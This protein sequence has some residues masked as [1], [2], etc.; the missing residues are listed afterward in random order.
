MKKL[1]LSIL[2]IALG[3]AVFADV[4][5]D[6]LDYYL[7]KRPEFDHLKEQKINRI[8][9]EIR[10][11]GNDPVVL[12]PL[13]VDLY[14]EYS[15]Y[16][17]DSATVCVKKLTDISNTL[18]DKEKIVSSTIKRAFG[19]L[20]SGLFKECFDI[21]SGLDVQNCSDE[22]KI[23]YYIV[24]SR[25][26]YDLADYNNS[27]DFRKTYDKKGNEI[28]DLAIALLPKESA[29]YLQCVGLKKMKSGDKEGAI[30]AYQEMMNTR[31]CS[32]HDIAIA[33]SSIAYMLGLQ[34]NKAEAEKQ[35]ILAAITDIKSSTKETVALRNLAKLLYE[36]GDLTH[37]AEYIR[38]ALDDAYFY[39]ARHRQLEIGY[40]LPI[41]EGER[42]NVIET[43]RDRI[44][45]ISIFISVLLI[46]L[47]IAFFIIWKQLKDLNKAKQIIQQSNENLTEVNN[48]LI[49]ANKIKDEYIGYF[50]SL[51]SEFIDK[52]EAF[53]KFVKRKV[54]NK[55]FED[56]NYIPK[57]LDAQN[58]REA[59][60]SRFDQVFLKLFPDFTAKFNE[61]LKP[62][63]QI[64]LKKGEL[65]NT[66][67]RIYAL[68]RLGINDNEKIAQFLGYS[69][70]TIYAYKTKIKNKALASNEEFK[71]K[72][73]EIKSI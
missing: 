57:N 6:S 52:M 35:L 42:M 20:Y 62:G 1:L 73:M 11:I 12:Y 8:K 69:V 59:L 47:I 53:Q 72:V 68:I 5:L 58:E 16:I 9:E 50:F 15:S 43:Q 13:Y 14:N 38:R 7:S 33:T 66:D 32:E 34:G 25:L 21:L 64:Q 41:I 70:N 46:A 61:L 24:K 17:Y 45:T 63:E 44:T 39:N 55:Q 29:R 48:H 18:N 36:R 10:E 23:D 3:N 40:I 2:F 51:N 26:Y 31:V 71:Q 28:I 49:E 54:N 27:P 19:Y 65:L 60:Y 30:A 37:A 56:L 67:L 4:N 22:T